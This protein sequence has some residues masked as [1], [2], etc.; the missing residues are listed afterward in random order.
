LLARRRRRWP[1][2]PRAGI[3]VVAGALLA[4]VVAGLAIAGAG[5]WLARGH[6]ASTGK[7]P[8]PRTSDLA[9]SVGAAGAQVVAGPGIVYLVDSR[10]GTVQRLDPTS[11]A[12]MGPPIQLSP[13][14]NAAGIDGVGTLWVPVPGLGELVPVSAG[15]PAPPVMVG[16]ARTLQ[17]TIAG[18]VPVVTDSAASTLTVLAESGIVR[19]ITLPGGFGQT[20]GLAVP[21]RTLGPEIPLMAWMS[22][23]LLVVDTASGSVS[24]PVVPNVT[25]S[26]GTP[27]MLG[28]SI[29]LPDQTSGELLVVDPRSGQVEQRIA[30]AGRHATLVARLAGQ[31]LVIDDQDSGAALLVDAGGRVHPL[32]ITATP[33]PPTPTPRKKP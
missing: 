13:P 1:A 22:H 21:P 28:S 18:G 4:V 27:Q 5:A 30:L 7:A 9:P 26:L 31:E 12:D 32:R 17:L 15:K 16:T 8:Q 2:L 29:Y 19:R 23:Q 10:A 6:A 24:K 3:I 33:R 25:G 14:L 11:L 20:T